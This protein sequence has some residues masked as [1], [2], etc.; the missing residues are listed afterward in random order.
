MS[1]A[2]SIVSVAVA[3]PR[4][5]CAA[6]SF[7]NGKRYVRDTRGSRARRRGS[8]AVVAMPVLNAFR[9]SLDSRSYNGASLL[10]LRGI[11]LKSHGSADVYAF[12][13]ALKRAVEEV[14]TGM[15]AHISERMAKIHGVHAM[16]MEQAKTPQLDTQLGMK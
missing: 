6:L 1:N 3:A 10:G 15:L 16:P 5:R 4:A 12:E 2:R 13:C 11:V 7:V 14:R 9:K 8:A